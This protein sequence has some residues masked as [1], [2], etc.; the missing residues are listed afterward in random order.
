M[1]SWGAFAAQNPSLADRG[2]ALLYQYGPGLGYL[3]TVR[4]DGGPRVHPV[5]PFVAGEHLSVFVVSH[6]PKCRDLLRDGRVAIHTFSA[7]DRDDEFC[8]TGTAH[9]VD[10]PAERAAALGAY[11]D[12]TV[13]EDHLLFRIDLDTAMYAAYEHRGQWPP[14]YTVW[15]ADD[16]GMG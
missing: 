15:R 7:E 16:A 13:G 8:V 14:A 10:D 4:A 3:A 5:C 6:S 9:L 2:L 12:P 11:H 1:A